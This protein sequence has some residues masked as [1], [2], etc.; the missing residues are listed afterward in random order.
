MRSPARKPKRSPKKSR[1]G[2]QDSQETHNP[3]RHVGGGTGRR[4]LYSLLR[5]R[6]DDEDGDDDDDD[7]DDDDHP[8]SPH[9][10][11]FLPTSSWTAA[12]V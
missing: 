11:S 8:P 2:P 5:S 7:D 9:P 1:R 4:P 10:H 3:T 12:A 6:D